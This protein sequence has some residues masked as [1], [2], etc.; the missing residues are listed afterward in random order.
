[1]IYL[2]HGATSFPK[3]RAVRRAVNRAIRTCGNPG[4]GGYKLAMEAGRQIYRCREAAAE[5]F[6]CRPEQVVFTGSCTQG[7][8]MGIHALFQPGD[9]VAITGSPRCAQTR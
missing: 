4:R 5:L 6:H 3:P 1:M 8:N 2:D 9:A 7:L